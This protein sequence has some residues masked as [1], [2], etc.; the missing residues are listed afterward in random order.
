MPQRSAMLIKAH[1]VVLY[2][3][4]SKKGPNFYLLIIIPWCVSII[5][6]SP[7]PLPVSSSCTRALYTLFINGKIINK[8]IFYRNI[9]FSKVFTYSKYQLLQTNSKTNSQETKFWNCTLFSV[10]KHKKDGKLG[11]RKSARE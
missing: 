11:I 1:S 10:L 9:F 6:T 3:N 8:L 4:E 5:I 2:Q 7:P